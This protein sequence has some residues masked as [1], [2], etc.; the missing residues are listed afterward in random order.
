MCMI[1]YLDMVF[2]EKEAASVQVPFSPAYL[3]KQPFF[4]CI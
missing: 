2:L 3:E 4:T 1:P